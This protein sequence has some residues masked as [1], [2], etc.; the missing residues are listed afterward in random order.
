MDSA[1]VV[2]DNMILA[3]EMERTLKRLGCKVV[4]SVPSVSEGLQHLQ[5]KS[6]YSL[7]ILDINLGEL[8]SY[9]L[10]KQIADLGIPKI[11]ASGYDSKFDMPAEL[12]HFQHLT[13]PI[14]DTTFATAIRN[15]LSENSEEADK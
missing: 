10:G 2:E 9:E 5:Q 12:R 14:D 7:A 15:A 6:D 3:M 11:F 1:L 13:K 8:T 4:H